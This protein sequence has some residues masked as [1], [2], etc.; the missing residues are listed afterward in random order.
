M[1]WLIIEASPTAARVKTRGQGD[2]NDVKLGLENVGNSLL[3]LLA[4]ITG[5]GL[6]RLLIL[7]VILL[8]F[9]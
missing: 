1:E 8:P 2:D 3:F 5:Q 6:Q 4:L 9:P 7:G